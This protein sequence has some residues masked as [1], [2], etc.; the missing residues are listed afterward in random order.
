MV[1]AADVRSLALTLPRTTEG[2][3]RDSVRFRIGRIVY[4]AFSPD[5]EFMGFAFPKEERAALVAAEPDKFFMPSK[6]DERYNWVATR[7]AA[8]SDTEMRELVVDAWRMCVPKRVAAA[9]FSS[10]EAASVPPHDTDVDG[11]TGGA[12]GS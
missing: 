12:A 6:S 5:E 7:L 8:L 4:A 11:T 10:A 3:V 9:Y 2:L 1:T